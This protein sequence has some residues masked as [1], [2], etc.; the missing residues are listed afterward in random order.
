VSAPSAK[1]A[2][3]QQVWKN[4]DGKWIRLEGEGS[5]EAHK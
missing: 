2:V 4:R 1:G 3:Q 5:Q